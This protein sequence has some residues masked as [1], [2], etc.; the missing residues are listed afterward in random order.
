MTTPS[1]APR[2]GGA[3]VAK[4]GLTAKPRQRSAGNCSGWRRETSGCQS[5]KEFAP[6]EGGT[7]QT[8]RGPGGP[9]LYERLCRR[10]AY[11]VTITCAEP[12]WP[13]KLASTVAVPMLMPVTRPW[14]PGA[15][16]TVTMPAGDDSQ[17]T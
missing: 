13:L 11:G 6:T 10:L 3:A 1:A 15:L 14:L 12:F 4:V 7:P 9:L 16:E 2:I 5:S 17:V 8:K